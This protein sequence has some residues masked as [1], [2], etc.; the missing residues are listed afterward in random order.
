VQ[1][2]STRAAVATKVRQATP[3]TKAKQVQPQPEPAAP[4]TP[5][6]PVL[7]ERLGRAQGPVTMSAVRGSLS[8][9]RM[10][11][12]L[13]TA[14][15]HAC[16]LDPGAETRSRQGTAFSGI[17]R[18]YYSCAQL[19][20]RMGVVSHGP[21]RTRIR[22]WRQ[23]YARRPAWLSILNFEQFMGTWSLVVSF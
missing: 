20:A 9:L 2:K 23:I 19:V 7:R 4:P 12:P 22:N 3:A 16:N 8:Q 17:C 1:T 13:I 18:V 11:G 15:W 14:V 6:A 5:K 21:K 10:T